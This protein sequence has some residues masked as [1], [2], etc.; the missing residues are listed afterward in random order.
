MENTET[1]VWLHFAISC[2]YISEEKYNEMLSDNE[3]IGRMIDHMINNPE[4]FA[5]NW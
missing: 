2:D 1:Q 4:K 5:R 3:R